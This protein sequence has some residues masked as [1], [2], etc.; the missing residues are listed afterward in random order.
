MFGHYIDGVFT[1]TI[2]RNAYAF[3]FITRSLNST[4]PTTWS[5]LLD[6]IAV[7]M[8]LN[9]NRLPDEVW[10]EM[11]FSRKYFR[12]MELDPSRRIRRKPTRLIQNVFVIIK[13]SSYSYLMSFQRHS[14]SKTIF[15]F[16]S[17]LCPTNIFITTSVSGVLRDID[18]FFCSM[19]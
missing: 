9:L 6:C 10:Y 7:G 16:K 2:N 14:S 5:S 19:I 4:I 18:R 1:I 15:V 8:R 11:A 12:V 13:I 17:A 3:F